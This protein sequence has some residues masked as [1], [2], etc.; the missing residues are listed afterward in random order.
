MV[1]ETMSVYKGLV[2]LKL[3]NDRISK[4]IGQATFCASAQESAEKVGGLKKPEFEAS[5]R[6][7]YDQC[8][9]LIRRRNAIKRAIVR[10][11]AVTTIQVGDEQMTVAEAI[12]QK[13]NGTS[14]L[15]QLWVRMD[16]QWRSAV[17]NVEKQN[18]TLE[19]RAEQFVVNMFGRKE[20]K[21]A[22]DEITKA[23]DSYIKRNTFAVV[24]AI[25]I[26]ERIAE[27]ESKIASFAADFD[28]AL[29]VSNA[30][31]QITI[32]Y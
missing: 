30:T 19:D 17:A 6:A 13:A 14:Y 8:D 1:A 12:D 31:T 28:S 23:K 10:S 27:L 4:A 16:A 22:S 32:E 18:A 5:A 21:T 2:E 9:G 25:N 26:P 20:S 3:L 24:D 29:S 7:S 15:Q 11:N